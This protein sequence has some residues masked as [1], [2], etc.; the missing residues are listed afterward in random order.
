MCVISGQFE[1]ENFGVINFL[2]KQNK[3][4]LLLFSKDA[5]KCDCKDI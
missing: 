2:K 3:K 4:K 1:V 5:F